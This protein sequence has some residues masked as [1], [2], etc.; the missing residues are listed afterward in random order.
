MRSI[1]RSLTKLE[2]DHVELYQLHHPEPDIPHEEILEPLHDL[3]QAGKV[4]F[5]G[6]CN[7]SAWRHAQTNATAAR[8]GWTQMV[9]VQG[10]YNLLRRHVELE[11]LP[12]AR[13]TTSASSRTG[14]SPT[15]G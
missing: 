6:E 7:Y 4:R 2:T 10:Y 1:D 5:I 9:S 14:R 13:R 12:S 11:V 15:A 8:N 3:V